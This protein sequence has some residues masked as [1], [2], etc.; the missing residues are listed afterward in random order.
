MI[1]GESP[2]D[3]FAFTE[4]LISEQKPIGELERA[5]VERIGSGLWR[6]KRIGKLEAAILQHEHNRFHWSPS[7]RTDEPWSIAQQA[8]AFMVS[9]NELAKLS[10][11]ETSIERSLF[12]TLHEF[13]RLQAARNGASVPT[14]VVVDIDVTGNS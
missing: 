2:T 13:Q 10:R 1:P 8:D 9:G 5:L 11:Y 12:K 4:N 3:F 14:P 7:S 6:L